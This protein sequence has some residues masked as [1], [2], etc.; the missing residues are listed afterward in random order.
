MN[1][2]RDFTKVTFTSQLILLTIIHIT[3]YILYVE[4]EIHN[5]LP[6]DIKELLGFWTHL[7]FGWL[8]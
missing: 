6:R 2:D 3:F 8:H 1:W 4:S 5:K 7:E